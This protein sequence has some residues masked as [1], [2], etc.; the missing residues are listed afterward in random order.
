MEKLKEFDPDEIPVTSNVL[1][2]DENNQ[3][4]LF[5]LDAH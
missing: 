2:P 4:L 5:Y 3:R 1:A